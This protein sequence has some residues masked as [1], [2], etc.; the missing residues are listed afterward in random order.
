[1][2]TS[3]SGIALLKEFEGLELE[4]YQDIAGI[5]TI[6]YGHTGPDVKPGMRISEREAEALLRRDLRSREDAV[7][8]LTSVSLN[9][10]EFDALVSFVYNVG[11]GAYRG[12]TARKRLNR[13]NRE[14]AADALTWWNKATVDGVLRPVLGLTRRRAA[15]RALFL[16][17]TNAPIVA[18]PTD[19]TENSRATPV[20]DP[21]RRENLASSRTI[22]GATV[23]GGAGVTSS[24]MGQR[25]ARELDDDSNEPLP[26]PSD[27]AGVDALPPTDDE[28]AD[29]P[30]EEADV[31]AADDAGDGAADGAGSTPEAGAADAE[32]DAASGEETADDEGD[33][34]DEAQTAEP[35]DASQAPPGEPADG[36]APTPIDDMFADDEAFVDDEDPVD[37]PLNDPVEDPVEDALAA[38]PADGDAAVA[39]PP[40]EEFPPLDAESESLNE[41]AEV[42]LPNAPTEYETHIVDAQ[43]QLALMIL[44]ILSVLFIIFTRVDD[45]LKYRR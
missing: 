37:D 11:I 41:M 14:G 17:P 36:P 7:S 20:E 43:I 1:M 22:Q 29:G 32:D 25:D 40:E 39:T 18:N 26:P 9:Q 31:D 34:A 19:L 12:S 38:D 10:N 30:S 42:G 3:E 6:G 33:E 45:W 24:S 15:E 21:P 28:A 5:W 13:G 23:A 27:D 8:S 35:A 2:K 4:A 16:K 44:I